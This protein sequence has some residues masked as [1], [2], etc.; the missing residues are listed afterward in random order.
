MPNGIVIPMQTFPTATIREIKEDLWAIA[1]SYP[2][3]RFLKEQ[4]MYVITAISAFASLDK[5]TNESKRLCDIQPYFCMLQLA[6]RQDATEISPDYE[7]YKVIGVLIGRCVDDFRALKNLE[8]NDF[9]YKM[10]LLGEEIEN[11]RR[12]MS[13]YEKLMYQYPLRLA[14]SPTMPET[15]KGRLRNSNF[16]IVVKQENDETSFTFCVPYN[17][18]P[19]KF[20]ESVL[21]KMART[22]HVLARERPSDFIFKICGRDE[23]LFGDYP[24]IQF[25]YIQETLSRDGVPAV[26]L[27]NIH[28]LE[29]FTNISN[30]PQEPNK[31]ETVT[32]NYKSSTTLRKRSKHTLSWNIEK[33]FQIT[34]HSIENLNCDP[35]RTFEIGVHLGLFHGERSLCAHK[36]SKEVGI[37]TLK[38]VNF[39]QT[40]TFDISLQNIPRMARLSLVIYEITKST[41][42]G[43][44]RARRVKDSKDLYMNPLAWANTTI[45]DYK[46]QLKTGCLTLYTWTYADDIQTDD[47]FHSLGTV[48]P[49]P[50]T[51]ECA[52][53]TLTF[54]NYDCDNIIL[55]PSE[56]TVL[57]HA[58][59]VAR[60]KCLNRDSAQ[61]TRTIKE[62]LAPYLGNDKLYE[63]HDQERNAIWS[64]R[65]DC[66][67][68]APEGLPFLLHCVEWNNRDEVSEICSL[69]KQWPTL[70]VERSLELLDYAYPDPTVRSFA[71][72]CLRELRDE[73]LLLYLLQLVQAIKHESYLDCDLVE[74]LLERALRN[75]RIG[76]YFFW[77]LRSEMQVPAMQTRFGL[78]L[79]AYLR[80]NKSHVPQLHK[81]LEC[82]EKLKHG[83]EMAKKGSKE[84]VRTMLQDFLAKERNSGV[85]EN[86]VSPLNP[87]FRC[88]GVRPDKCKVMDS[89]MRPL[90][91]VFE[92]ADMHGDDIYIIFKNGDD[93]R[94]DM[95]TLQMLRVM[96]QIWK[97]EGYDFRMNIYACISMDR[98]LGM[99]EVVLNA[100]TIANIQKEKG[101]FSATSPFKKGS[102]LS[103]LKEHNTTDEQ[104][105]KAIQEFTLSCAGY[106]VA[107]YVLGVADRHSDN[108]MVKKMD[109]YFI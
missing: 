94:Q 105:E 78:I 41:K 101:M 60:T 37:N 67:N 100:E 70:P 103:W 74:F 5:F 80:G 95:L 58:A 32:T 21:S 24:L 53:I 6:E 29:V 75:Q 46:H 79:E 88:K 27:K 14:K 98:R 44:S 89:K 71:I 93:L 11:E 2:L 82:L 35:S 4:S 69:L 47:L 8:I 33:S 72:R 42:L 49:N 81:Q 54:H 63:M 91:V 61:D 57:A 90:F 64:K 15:I 31:T 12:N 18:S 59:E 3:Y 1:K 77:H 10:S 51:E 30:T 40:L 92:N 106:C 86:V 36:K 65:L 84:K 107:T 34:L 9:R 83:S 43:G 20:A 28:N 7:I 17:I 87:S 62:V 102:L 19:Y 55:Y 50:R 73:E 22:K 66:L 38:C 85:F 99:I 56:E 25:I 26:V 104:L 16:V 23:Y 48:E 52:A 96:D 109:N 108:I 39:E 68:D 97:N 45:Y 13:W 76:H